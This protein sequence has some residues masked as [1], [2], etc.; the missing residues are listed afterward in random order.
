MI[1]DLTV[2][3]FFLPEYQSSCFFFGA[4]DGMFRHI[5]GNRFHIGLLQGLLAGQL[6][7]TIGGK[8][9]FDPHN[10]AANGTLKSVWELIWGFP[11]PLVAA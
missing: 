11:L 9:V 2:C 6:K 10:R 5:H 1:C 4:F 3:R 7:A 8:R